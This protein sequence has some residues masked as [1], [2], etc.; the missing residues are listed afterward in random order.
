MDAK[1]N[2]THRHRSQCPRS[3]FILHSSNTMAKGKS[4]PP[5][6]VTIFGGKDIL[7]LTPYP[8]LTHPCLMSCRFVYTHSG[9]RHPICRT[10]HWE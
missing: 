5:I 4:D 7:S 10:H 6:G 1:T 2:Q 3:F 8:E 9:S